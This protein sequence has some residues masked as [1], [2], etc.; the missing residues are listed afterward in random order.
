MTRQGGAA[1]GSDT[2]PGRRRRAGRVAAIAAVL[3]IV[4]GLIVFTLLPRPSGPAAAAEAYLAALAR[5]DGAAAG[6]LTVPGAADD[7]VRAAD[8]LAAAAEWISAAGVDSLTERG[9]DATAEVTFTLD[10]AQHAATLALSNATGTWLIARP[11]TTQVRVH[12]AIGAGVTIGGAEGAAPSGGAGLVLP[13]DAGMTDDPA[14]TLAL[15]PAVYTLAPAPAALL[16]G[17]E[18][19]AVTGGDPV[20]VALVPTLR[21]EARAAADAQLRAYLASC[22]TPTDAV[23]AH[24]GIRVPWAADLTALHAL[25]FRVD[26]EP[27]LA[28]ADDGRGFAATGGT[29][30]ATARGIDD[31]G[32]E[33]SV[34]YRD[35]DW[36]VRGSLR[37]T[38]DGLVLE[39]W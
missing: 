34:S 33:A 25:T 12:S 21:P 19:L 18:T 5:G 31:A 37:F 14:T 8:A 30:V 1:A 15:L 10:G 39:L 36:G 32:A 11:L 24:C 38:L 22:T 27:V 16:A 29:L 4:G 20:T 2:A 13:Y 7:P 9:T 17:G 6:A 28:L 35:S 23:P 3:L 26:A